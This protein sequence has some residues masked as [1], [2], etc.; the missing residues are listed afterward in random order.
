MERETERWP[1]NFASLESSVGGDHGNQ[2]LYMVYV[3]EDS[4]WMSEIYRSQLQIR[5]R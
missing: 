5:S 2:M 1:K 4:D 3:T